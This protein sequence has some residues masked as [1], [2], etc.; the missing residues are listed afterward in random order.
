MTSPAT[1]GLGTERLTLTQQL[2]LNGVRV[3]DFILVESD[4][5]HRTPQLI[6][7][8]SITSTSRD[9]IR[10]VARA[11]YEIDPSN[12]FDYQRYGTWNLQC[13][14]WDWP[15][16]NILEDLLTPSD[17]LTLNPIIDMLKTKFMGGIC[18][19]PN[20]ME[21]LTRKSPMTVN[22]VHFRET[23]SRAGREVWTLCPFCMGHELQA[24][25]E[26]LVTV[27]L[28]SFIP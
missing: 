1:S 16:S 11:K 18:L 3:G 28:E 19:Y 7:V 4:A 8:D 2:A 25:H 20:C 17:V 23:E 24:R 6:L 14:S 10:I 22:D 27:S 21:G 15:T 12:L 26:C 5:F 13:M 9:L